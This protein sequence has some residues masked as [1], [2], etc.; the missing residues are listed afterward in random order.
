[1]K[2]PLAQAG[3]SLPVA[4]FVLV[5]LS[6]LGAAMTR[7][8]ATGAQSLGFEVLSTRAF[9]AAESGAQWGMNTLFPPMGPP[10]ATCFAQQNLSF[11]TSGLNGCSAQVTCAGP[12]VVANAGGATSTQFRIS[13]RGACGSGTDMATRVLEVGAQNP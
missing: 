9:Y 7:M 8:L 5:L 13:S 3:F 12:V 4:I 2:Q 10:A 11:S 1:M 6:L